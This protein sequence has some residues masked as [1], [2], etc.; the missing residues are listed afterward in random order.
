LPL[1]PNS[2]I[3][4]PGVIDGSNVSGAS[5]VRLD[6]NSFIDGMTL[7]NFNNYAIYIYG[8]YAKASNCF[9]KN[10]WATAIYINGHNSSILNCIIDGVNGSTIAG[11]SCHEPNILIDNTKIMNVTGTIPYCIYISDATTRNILVRDCTL[12]NSSYGIYAGTANNVSFIHNTIYHMTTAGMRSACK[13]TT[14]KENIFIGTPTPVT[15]VAPANS[16][17]ISDNIGYVTENQGNTSVANNGTIS[18]GL[19]AAPS[20]VGVTSQNWYIEAKV[21]S[22]NAATFTVFLLDIRTNQAAVGTYY[23][24]WDAKV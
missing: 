10:S 21:I 6:S 17:M 12:S 18:H 20:F 19:A 9:I 14:M 5:G 24:F 2:R 3:I 4:G 11:I 13:D 22:K 8:P 23:V 7:K 15:L 1:P 16:K